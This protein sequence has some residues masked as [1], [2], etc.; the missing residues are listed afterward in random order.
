MYAG[1][2][3]LPCRIIHPLVLFMDRL[4]AKGLRLKV[5]GAIG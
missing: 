5:L 3:A 1:R 4:K 2:A